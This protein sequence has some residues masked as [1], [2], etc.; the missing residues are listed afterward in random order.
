MRKVTVTAV[1]LV[2]MTKKIKHENQ[3]AAC[4][5]LFVSYKS[6]GYGHIFVDVIKSEFIYKP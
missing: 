4:F 1:I 2:A 5:I 3:H 6:L